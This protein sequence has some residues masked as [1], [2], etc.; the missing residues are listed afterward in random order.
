MMTDCELSTSTNQ[1]IRVFLVDDHRTT[2]WGLERLIEGNQPRMQL[3]GS[4]CN[5][6][7]LMERA[8]RAQPNVIVMDLDL[9][10]E[11]ATQLIPN[12]VEQTGAKV[13]VLTG[14]RDPQLHV[15]VLLNGA[16]G[17][18]RKE[19]PAEIVLHAIECVHR[20]EVWLSRAGMTRLMAAMAPKP[21]K[22]ADPEAKKMSALTSRE[23][24][25]VR[26]VA[27]AK[28]A[29]STVIAERLGMSEHTLRNHLNA[30]YDKLQI[31][32]RVELFIYANANGLSETLQPADSSFPLTAAGSRMAS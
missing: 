4:A 6:T 11:S 23:R 16:L 15:E 24:E 7:E 22:K 19:E 17:V 1:A 30:I 2:L 28:G 21:A 18:V 12:I 29:K 27:A 26:E 14:I 9:G 8:G 32:G 13:L 10:G 5:S 3:V 31:H 25:V 20:G